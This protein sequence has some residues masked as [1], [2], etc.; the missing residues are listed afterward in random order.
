MMYQ[1]SQQTHLVSAYQNKKITIHLTFSV[2]VPDPVTN[3]SEPYVQPFE[4]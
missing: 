2:N 4:E 1:R 3:T